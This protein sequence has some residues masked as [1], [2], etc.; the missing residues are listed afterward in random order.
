MTGPREVSRSEGWSVAR[1][2][3]GVLVRALVCMVVAGVLGAPLAL[4]WA[5]THTEVVSQ[6]GTS[7]TTFSLST[8]GISEVR[9]GIAGTVFVPE[10][11]GAVG[12]VATVIGPGDPGAGDG[13]LA[14]YVRPEMVE[15]YAGLFHHPEQAV[16]EVVRLVEQEFRH[17]LLVA[18]SAVAGVGGA[19]LFV[20]SYLLPWPRGLSGRRTALRLG[21]AALLLVTAS[22][23]LAWVQVQARTTGS[24]ATS[25][26]YELPVFDGTL[27]EG[28]TTDSP[29]LRAVLGGA[30][31][32]AQVLVERQEAAVAAYRDLASANL[33]DQ[34]EAMEGPRE[35]ELAVLMQSDMHCNLAMIDLQAQVVSQLREQHGADA[36]SLLAVTGDLTTNGT[37]AEGS[38]IRDEAAIAR[39]VPVT[40]I[41]GN[42][43]S[44][45]SVQQMVQA[46][47]SVLDGATEE[48]NGVR[49]LGDGDPSRT[50]LFGGS[51]LRG[52]ETQH[53]QGRRLHDVA[54]DGGAPD[55]VLVHEGYA[56]AAFLGV[57]DMRDF[58]ES[59]TSLVE[60]VEDEVDDVP[61]AAVLYGHWHRSVQP[62]VAWN[63][64]GTWTFVMELDTSG[65]TVATSTLGNFSTPWSPPRQPASFPVLFLD[66]E[67]RL[68]TGYQLYRFD[69]D[70][71]VAVQARV[72]VGAP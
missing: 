31:A 23:A 64:D 72:D 52:Q 28:S 15:L 33:V 38:C 9:L 62:R 4:S 8:G 34:A 7:P 39:D 44:A 48:I 53:G 21:S 37:A 14:N 6:I 65:G 66:T 20:L 40:A 26:T 42:H 35:G 36:L 61:A 46:G 54:A 60:P 45:V 22:G 50:E 51:S 27:A 67:T 16:D 1:T 12:I 55:L 30:I 56:A 18:E 32:K 47:M 57:E 63:S 11:Q 17:Q 43:E 2:S 41:T 69:I 19:L 58:F 25:G 3:G 70:A 13:D 68:V 59:P 49:V 29:V 24:G 71:T 5:L 10:S